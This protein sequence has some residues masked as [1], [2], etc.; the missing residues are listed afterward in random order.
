LDDRL[1]V[2]QD[3]SAKLIAKSPIIIFFM[4]LFF[5]VQR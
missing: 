5:Q 1:E 4:I 2:V 3:P